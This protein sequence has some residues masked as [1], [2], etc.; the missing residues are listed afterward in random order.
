MSTLDEFDPSR[1]QARPATSAEPNQLWTYSATFQLAVL[2]L[3][4]S[5]KR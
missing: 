2:K 3:V 5:R 4:V 1:R